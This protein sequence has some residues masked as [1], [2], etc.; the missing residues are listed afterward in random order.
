MAGAVVLEPWKPRDGLK[1]AHDPSKAAEEE[2]GV[3]ERDD[4][5]VA[6]ALAH[7]PTQQSL[8]PWSMNVLEF[9]K[10]DDKN[11]HIDFVHTAANL[12]AV[13][14]EIPNVTRL[15]SKLIAGRIIPAIVTTTAVVSGLVCFELI[16]LALGLKGRLNEKTKFWDTP[17]RNGFCN[18]AIPR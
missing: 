1:I 17:Y 8:R 13:A 4:K 18:L 6:H 10:D 14:Y 5:L 15:Q 3:S 7:L 11:F 2:E 16:K 9:E 12:R